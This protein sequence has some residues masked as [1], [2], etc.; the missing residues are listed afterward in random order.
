ML[1]GCWVD[2]PVL[3]GGNS[4]ATAA[5]PGTLL[6]MVLLITMV[7]TGC[8]VMRSLTLPQA[9]WWP[10][11]VGALAWF[12]LNATLAVTLAPANAH[13]SKSKAIGS[14]LRPEPQMQYI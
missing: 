13:A 10:S 4:V 11:A 2:L 6:T 14:P 9:V 12:I 5:A 8:T 7:G 1:S 3:R